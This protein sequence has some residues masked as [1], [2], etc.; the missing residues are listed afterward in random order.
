M[1]VG[2]EFDL[3]P[4]CNRAPGA[5]PLDVCHAQGLPFCIKRDRTGKPAHWNQPLQLRLP[6][7]EPHHRHRVL[8]AVAD[9]QGLSLRIEYQRIRAGAKGIGR[10]LPH[11]DGLHNRLLLYI[12]HRECVAPGIRHDHMAL[13][14]RDRQ[15]RGMQAS[16]NLPHSRP[17]LQAHDGNRSFACNMPH[18]IHPHTR[19]PPGGPC[20]IP[21]PGTPT[22]PV[23]NKRPATGQNDIVGGNPHIP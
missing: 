3:I 11:P 16:V 13:I 19:A 5:D 8:G 14:G 23:A 20:E 17:A 10:M 12:Q 21:R 1:L 18:R 9:I 7:L 4:G 22:T 6:R 2:I 15:R